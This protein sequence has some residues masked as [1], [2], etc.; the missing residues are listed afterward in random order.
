MIRQY[1]RCEYNFQLLSL[2]SY[3][4]IKMIKS[5]LTQHSKSTSILTCLRNLKLLTCYD[6]C[7]TDTTEQ[8]RY[9]PFVGTHIR[10]TYQNPGPISWL[11]NLFCFSESLRRSQWPRGLRHELSSPARTL[12]SWVRISL[13]AWLFV[14]VFLFIYVQAL[15][16]ADPPSKESYRLS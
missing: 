14:S 7:S 8:H 6:F 5:W 16:R 1:V 3:M 15:R 10:Y 11:R 2:L 9:T 12:G 13:K 4:K